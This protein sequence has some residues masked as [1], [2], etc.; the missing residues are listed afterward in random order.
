MQANAAKGNI[1]YE[2]FFT[3]GVWMNYFTMPR[4]VSAVIWPQE[5]SRVHK[6]GIKCQ[7]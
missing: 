1:E 7:S 4:S 6:G 2:Y 3:K 5:L